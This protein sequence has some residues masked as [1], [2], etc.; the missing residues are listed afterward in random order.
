MVKSKRRSRLAD[1]AAR[2]VRRGKDTERKGAG[3]TAEPARERAWRS[4]A[5]RLAEAVILVQGVA[6]P[7]DATD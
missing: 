1:G 6:G 5:D 4:A 7:Q 3:S 2:P